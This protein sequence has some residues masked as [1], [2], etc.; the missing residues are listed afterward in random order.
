MTQR[1]LTEVQAI[2]D[3]DYVR[4]NEH[5]SLVDLIADAL[6]LAHRKGLDAYAILQMAEIHFE[7]ETE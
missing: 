4:D 2:I 3:G 6:H 1:D 7:Q 5:E